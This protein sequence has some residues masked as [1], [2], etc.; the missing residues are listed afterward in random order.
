[1]RK[2][3]AAFPPPTWRLSSS[4]SSISLSL[5][6]L[7]CCGVLARSILRPWRAPARTAHPLRRR[8]FTGVSLHY[9][10]ACCNVEDA[11]EG[12]DE[13]SRDTHMG[14]SVEIIRS[15]SSGGGGNSW[16]TVGRR[17][18][19]DPPEPADSWSGSGQSG[20][21][22]NATNAILA[23]RPFILMYPSSSDWWPPVPL[24]WTIYLFIFAS[25]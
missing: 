22:R 10:L 19:E 16:V 14:K 9:I 17:T 13:G 24:R 7:H 6:L 8:C 15:A 3:S 12:V 4:P 1:M 5:S 20:T 25:S 23:F 18:L 11:S 2:S 21:G